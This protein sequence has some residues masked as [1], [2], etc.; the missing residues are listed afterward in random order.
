M[1]NIYKEISSSISK[2]YRFSKRPLHL[3][4]PILTKK[5]KKILNNVL[6]SSYVSSIG[7]FV[8]KFEKKIERFT[9]AKH[10]ICLSSGTSALHLS[11]LLSG[12]KSNHE[13]IIPK[14]NFIASTNAC[15]YLGASPHFVDCSEK[16]LCIDLEKLERYLADICVIK[17]GKTF[18][19]KTNKQI[20]ACI[21][22]YSFGYTFDIIKLKSICNKYK[23]DLIEDS[24]E[25]LGTFY[26]NKHVGTF[27][28]FGILSFNGNKIITTGGGGAIL[29]NNTLLAKR[30]RHISNVSKVFKKFDTLHD[31]VGYNYKMTNLNAALGYSQISNLKNII[32]KKNIL[33][34]FLRKNLKQFSKHFEIYNQHNNDNCNNWMQLLIVKDKKLKINKLLEILKKNKIESKRAWSDIDKFNYLKKFPSMGNKRNNFFS[35]IILLPSNEF[36]FLNK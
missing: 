23:I 25:A 35:R 14:F 24:A 32:K 22:T 29:T 33:N 9:K 20:K 17:N 36:K 27:G 8:R 7:P 5:E 16:T 18:N 10:V 2:L 30:A 11:L 3:H 19:K 34:K 21:P 6:D 1:K 12:V 13:V 26:K 31:E 4:K 28:K 15:L